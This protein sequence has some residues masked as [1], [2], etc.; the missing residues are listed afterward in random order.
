VAGT[1]PIGT[2]ETV[3]PAGSANAVGEADANGDDVAAAVAEGVAVTVGREVVVADG[4]GLWVRTG[5][6]A[7]GA[8]GFGAS[9]ASTAGDGAPVEQPAARIA[10][11]IA[12]AASDGSERTRATSRRG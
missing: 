1:L 4:R 11:A 5:R 7:G 6:L 9:V 2:R 8:V 10:M 12:I 3:R